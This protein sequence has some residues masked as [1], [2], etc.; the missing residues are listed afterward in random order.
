ML[1]STDAGGEGLNLQF[2]HVI[3]NFDMPWN[4]MRLEQ[5]IGRVDRIGQ[6]KAVK[7]LNF[8]LSDTVEFR[9]REV[10]EAKLAVILD[11]FGVDKTS[12]VLDSAD[13]E[14]LFDEL[15]IDAILH[16][17]RIGD[18]V[19]T[20]VKAVGQHLREAQ[21][22]RS[23][24][25]GSEAMDTADARRVLDHPLHSWV[26]RMTVSYLK[27]HGGSARKDKGAWHLRW[28]DGTEMPQAVFSAVDAAKCPGAQ[29]LTLENPRVRGLCASLPRFVQG[30]PV[31]CVRLADLPSDLR[32]TW[33][34]WR[35]SVQ[36]G[37]WNRQRMMPLFVSDKG[38]VFAPTAR[39]IWDRLLVEDIM[40]ISYLTGEDAEKAMVGLRDEAERS[41]RAIYEDLLRQHQQRLEQER[42]KGEYA[43]TARR[44]ALSRI[45]LPSVREH[46]L[47]RLGQEHQD[48]RREMEQAVSVIPQL[49]PVLVVWVEGGGNG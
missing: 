40:P 45:G 31:A 11:E 13:A 38:R 16:P 5:R 48:W 17:D 25:G 8:L 23:L 46:H 2:C 32:G 19:E 12:D 26:E 35:I 20:A 15:Y 29:H 9:V 4:P 14:R 41:G 33:S 18:N 34:V 39:A 10:L 49:V 42:K 6:T 43:F 24:L 30:Q 37:T 47:A 21:D 22:G 7:A 44:R 28:P 1:I 36:A 3:V 27:A